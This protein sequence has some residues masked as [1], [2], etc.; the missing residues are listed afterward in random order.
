MEIQEDYV[1]FEIAKLLK[2]KE[3]D[4]L[5]KEAWVIT[6][7]FSDYPEPGTLLEEPDEYPKRA[8]YNEY[9]SLCSAPTQA[10]AV[11]GLRIKHNIHIQLH[12]DDTTTELKEWSY[13]IYDL[14]WGED[15]EV[16]TAAPRRGRFVTPEE[17]TEAAILYCLKHL[18]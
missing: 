14:F 6:D 15:R 8:N 12:V 17:A 5:C 2:E 3:F 11:K 10:L 13:S 18:I 7:E 1:S 16:H 9:D 4:I